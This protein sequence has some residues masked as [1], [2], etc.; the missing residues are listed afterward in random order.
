MSAV[1]QS[2]LSVT[3]TVFP[4]IKINFCGNLSAVEFTVVWRR[5]GEVRGGGG[6]KKGRVVGGG[7]T[8]GGA[9]LNFYCLLVKTFTRFLQ[10]STR[11]T[12]IFYKPS[13]GGR[14]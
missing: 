10:A 11:L 2:M 7:S 1:V 13:S 4:K 9:L 3:I 8:Q 12:A 6:E 14:L 5:A